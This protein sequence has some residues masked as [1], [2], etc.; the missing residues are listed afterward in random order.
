MP[1]SHKHDMNNENGSSK[2]LGK[3]L[4]GISNSKSLKYHSVTPY[5]RYSFEAFKEFDSGREEIYRCVSFTVQ[6]LYYKAE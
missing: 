2:R 4:S 3:M 6:Q 5:S 1:D